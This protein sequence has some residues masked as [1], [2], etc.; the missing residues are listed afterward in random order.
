MST[1]REVET[2][3]ELLRSTTDKELLAQVEGILAPV[4]NCEWL[5]G[6]PENQA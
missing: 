1:T 5:S 4:F 2:S 3:L 6:R